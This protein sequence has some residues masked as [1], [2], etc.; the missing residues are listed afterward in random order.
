MISG[1][2]I[3]ITGNLVDDV[4]LNFTPSGAA[5]AR[6]RVAST[7]RYQDKTTQ[8][9]KD[10]EPLFLTVNAWRNLGENCAE[11]LTRGMRITVVGRIKQR[12]YETQE[13]QKRTA[14]EIEADD[15]GP[16]LRFATAKVTKATRHQPQP[17]FG[18]QGADVAPPPDVPPALEDVWRSP[19]GV[20]AYSGY[21]EE[22]PF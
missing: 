16:S 3:T 21:P 8:T 13:G 2:T 5:V 18:P 15:V 17:G 7:P 6:F 11:S 14:Y 20:G 1:N 10:G 12:S 19:A 9:W 22:P 4:N